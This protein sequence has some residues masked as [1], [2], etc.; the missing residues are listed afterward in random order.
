ME[1][2]QVP[3]CH[4]KVSTAVGGFH[5]VGV[6]DPQRVTPPP[7]LEGTQKDGRE[8]QPDNLELP[9][10]QETEKS[11]PASPLPH[12][13]LLIHP[14][15]DLWLKTTNKQKVWVQVLPLHHRLIRVYHSCFHLFIQQIWM[16]VYYL[17]SRHLWTLEAY[18]GK[19]PKVLAFMG[20]IFY[21]GNG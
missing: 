4:S 21:T 19:Y 5:P 14:R 2:W 17:P 8:T 15:G 18:I 10:T 20:L 1:A 9:A 12:S 11:C 16:S 6:Q 13:L 7:D 3:E